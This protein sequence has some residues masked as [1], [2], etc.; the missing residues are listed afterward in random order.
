MKGQASL[1]YLVVTAALLA[2]LAVTLPAAS[3][4]AKAAESFIAKTSADSAAGRLAALADYVCAV[5]SG[6]SATVTVFV[7]KELELP[8]Q[9]SCGSFAARL[10]RGVNRVTVSN[11]NGV[12]RPARPSSS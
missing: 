4:A 8:V 7:A 5:G 3:E 12:I 6:N 11:D 9:G 1:E 2:V 10:S